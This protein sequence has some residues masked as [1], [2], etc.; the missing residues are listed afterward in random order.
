MGRTRALCT[1]LAIAVVMTSA[2]VKATVVAVD[3]GHSLAKAGST[4]ASGKSE[5]EYNQALAREVIVELTAAG[6]ETQSI[7]MKGE[8]DVLTARTAAAKKAD[9]FL[10]IHHDSVQPQFLSMADRFSGYGVFVSRKNPNPQLSLRCAQ[11]IADHLKAV[12]RA[13]S[14][15][16]AEPIKGE[17]RPLVDSGRG[18][19]WFDDLVVLRTAQQPAV[20]VEAA[21][22]VNP[23]EDRMI[24]DENNRRLIG[25]AIASGVSSCLQGIVE[26]TR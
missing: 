20:L 7:G 5:F 14:L 6:I 12:G 13:P 16:H 9:L 1:L 10:S 17:N 18:I 3:V 25:A 22:I 2:T 4:S 8:M 26:R 15:H 24:S 23:A 21:V 19:Y 11:A